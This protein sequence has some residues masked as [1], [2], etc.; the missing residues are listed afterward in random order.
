MKNNLSKSYAV[1][2]LLL[3]PLDVVR[4]DSPV[5]DASMAQ[6]ISSVRAMLQGGEDVNGAQGDGMTAL[7]WAA[8]NKDAELADL[9]IYAGANMAAVTRI[10]DYTPLHMASRIGA[11]DVVESLLQGGSYPHALTSSGDTT[12]LHLAAV[13]GN[14]AVIGLL[15]EYGADINVRESKR[16]QTPLMFAAAAGRVAAVDELLRHGA[17]FSLTTD[18]LDLLI[19]R[20]QDVEAKK[21]RDQVL[22]AFR[23]ES[24]SEAGTWQP[25][26]NEVYT[27]INAA[28][29][30]IEQHGTE[31]PESD[32]SYVKS[33]GKSGGMT[34]LLYTVR[35]GHTGVALALLDS[36]ADI[37]QVSEG[38]N[39]SAVLI[40]AIN[41]HFDLAL[42]LLERGADLNIPSDAGTTPLFAVLN[43]YWAPKSRYPQQQAYRQQ[44]SDYLDT[45]ETLLK[46]GAD[47]NVRLASHLWFMEYTFSNLEIDTTGATAFWRAA[48]ALDIEA[49]EL[50]IAHGADP[51]IPTIRPIPRKPPEQ[52][53]DGNIISQIGCGIGGLA[54][55]IIS[56][57][58][59]DLDDSGLPVV[60]EGGPGV[61][62]IHVTTGHGYGVGYAGNSHRHVPDSWVAATEYL[63]EE[64]GAD[65]NVRDHDGFTPLHNAAS[66]GDNELI[67]IL[68]EQG[69]DVTVVN[70]SGQT[71]ADIANGPKQ[72]TQPYIETVEL[73]ESLGSVNN[74]NCVSC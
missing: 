45:M 1:L 59:S 27:A 22:E 64:H 55:V 69:A 67:A 5:A 60:P 72:R 9:L 61:Y 43:S 65:V 13:A 66:R 15:L 26:P 70:R 57:F 38:D 41:G 44:Q 54:G 8:E 29:D 14:S 30:Y 40:A 35:E 32:S 63:I 2:L 39:T 36:G 12:P 6:D 48:H 53:C 16:G 47:P 10:G 31:V 50:L 17:D 71:T 4:A 74:Q 73:L 58:V 23:D 28:H 42:A 37:N 68:V 20:A 56:P 25:S 7:H 34:A 46:A 19:Q 21:H 33:V 52:E 24:G 18:V 11:A 62:P 3:L 51:D 49:M